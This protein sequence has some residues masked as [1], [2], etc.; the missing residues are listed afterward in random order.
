MDID[1]KPVAPTASSSSRLRKNHHWWRWIAASVAALILLIVLAVAAFIKLAPTPAPLAL[2]GGAV[3]A[4]VGQLGG[5][6]QVAAGSAAAFRVSESAL[7]LSNYT[8]GR[9]AD[10][11]GT[12]V[13]ARDQI[14]RASFTV[15]LAT[16]T[17][18]GKTEPQFATSLDTKAYPTA[19]VR[20]VRPVALGSAFTS[21]STA[22]VSASAILTMRGTSRQVTVTFT[23]RRDGSAIQAAGSI[24][25]RF[26]RWGISDPAGFGIFGSLANHG[27]AEFL[28][29]AQRQ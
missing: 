23:V 20:L 19:T 22:T 29:I 21:G 16:I 11:T 1:M 24:P 4:P 12:V 8:S 2:P 28:L 5:T 9:T 14:T 7:G 17:A 27:A 3:S 6:W 25:V 18:G 13:I 26:S 10:V 15:E